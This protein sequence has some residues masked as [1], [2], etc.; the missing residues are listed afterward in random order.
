[1]EKLIVGPFQAT[2][3]STLIIIN[4]LDECRDEEPASAILS[5]LSRYVHDIPW[6]KFFITGRPE[7]RIRS[8]F[9]LASLQPITEVLK[10]HEVDRSS[11]DDDIK[12]FFGTRLNDIA[13]ARSDCSF[14]ED[15]P[16]SSD[17]RILCKKAT[18][19]F[20]YASTVVKFVTS[21][22]R[23]PTEQ[24]D[25][26][27]SSAQSTT[28]EGKGIDPLYTQVLEQAV[29]N[30]DVD[31]MDKDKI[32]SRFKTVVGT[33]LLVFNPLSVGALSDLLKIS[34][35]PTTLHSLHSL[36]LIPDKEKTDT[37][38]KPF[39]KSFPDFITDPKRCRDK[40]FYVDPAVHHAEILL[41]CLN[42]MKEK[43]K[44][45][46]CSLDD[47]VILSDVKN[48]PACRK[49][50]IGDSL[51][52]ACCF[53]TKHLL[54][55]PGSSAGEVQKAI[56]EFFNIH[57]L[58]WIEVLVVT[59]NLGIGVYAMNDI[60]KWYASVSTVQTIYQDMC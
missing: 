53:W 36:L 17:I 49:V 51:E 9:L 4:A 22:N 30:V 54:E 56:D 16:N 41:S 35:I 20:I 23:I 33:V 34:T 7:P 24:L 21:K 38:I 42:L 29:D 31:D 37:P 52:Y 2:K 12:L 14:A 43:L 32:Y 44:K 48:L 6:V 59:R 8:G 46:I 58:H 11:V 18:G 25:L 50:N 10:L 60:E 47:Y 19:F 27:V 55:M 39:H 45:N 13:K 28:H 1:M 5:V 57:L 26:I 3:T 40:W 15:W